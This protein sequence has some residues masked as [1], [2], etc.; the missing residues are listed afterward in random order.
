[1]ELALN[2][3]D[4]VARY[5]SGSGTETIVLQYTVKEGDITSN[6]DYR[7]STSL[8]SQNTEGGY[9][10]V[11]GHVRRKSLSPTTDSNLDISHI[12][13]MSD[14]HIIVIDGER[15]Q[16]LDVHFSESDEG[17]V[18]ARG[19]TLMIL[20]PFSAPV[21]VDESSPPILGLLLGANE[22]WASYS[23]GSGSSTLVF[24]YTIVVGDS[25]MPLEFHYRQFCHQTRDCISTKGLVVRLSAT[26]ELDAD[27]ITGFSEQGI[28]IA[29]SPE[30]GVTIDTSMAPVTTVVSTTTPT[31]A[32]TYG[33]GEIIDIILSFTDQVFLP[34]AMPTLLLNTGNFAS[35]YSGQDTDTL[36]FRFIS[37][38]SDLTSKFDWA[39][40]PATSSA[41]VCSVTCSIENANGIG[42]DIRFRDSENDSSLVEPLQNMI[43]FDPSTPQILSIR[44]DKTKSPY[45]HPSCTYTVGEEINIHVTFDRPVVVQGNA[46]SLVMNV[47][48]DVENNRAVHIPS[49]ST[50]YELAFLY[51]VGHGHSSNGASLQ[52]I[53]SETLCSLQLGE[54]TEI[55]GAASIPT[56]D[57]DLA[58]PPNSEHGLSG[59][60][61]NP[62]LIVTSGQ[63]SIFDVSS[64]PSDGDFSPGDTIEISVQFSRTVVVSG[65]PFLALDVGTSQSGIA[66][67]KDGS[68]TPILIFEY[69]VGLDHM[70][71]GLQYVDA[72]SLYLG[73]D[74]VNSG[75]IKQASTNPSIDA[76]LD[77]T[78]HGTV[79]AL[80]ANS[81][82][83]IDSREP[84][85][86]LIS[87]MPGEYSTGNKVLI[88]VQF[89]RP[90]VIDGKPSL[91]LK[92]G[93]KDRIAEY[94]S[95]PNYHTIQFSYTVQLGDSTESLDYWSDEELL[96]S[97]SM[98]LRLNGGWI[99][100]KSTNPVLDA[101]LHINPIDGFLDG[102]KVVG[103]TEGV[104]LFRD[105]KIGQRGKDFKIWFQSN[106]SSTGRALQVSELVKIDASIEYEVQGDLTIRDPGDLYG[107]AVS[108]HEGMLAVGAPGKQNPTPEIQVVTVHSE[109]AIEEHEV[110]VIA[111]SVNIERIHRIQ[112]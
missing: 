25:S 43:A 6:L 34:G 57:A 16:M 15:P 88:Q 90:V 14:T 95:Q 97:S 19:D 100:L 71:P 3:Y 67:F 39:L 99:R 79:G 18:F 77:L 53:C 5:I 110:Q 75:S 31:P 45:C 33:V 38:E 35:Y 49:M 8:I 56:L 69:V 10:P 29:T 101:D 70:T 102:D 36:T 78:F 109:S 103:V 112:R 94:D 89:S 52:Y 13:S 72:H 61:F 82:I 91:A 12:A 11:V 62:I 50:E 96:P 1:L 64:M 106:V 26:L 58:L 81:E 30:T 108:L 9:L 48:D 107:S 54:A 20:V 93:L 83:V 4:G 60:E 65:E 66:S 63:P 86:L 105:L 32:G 73:F 17:G 47:G 59:D 27:L 80:G 2:T 104:A 74:G 92:A 41:L 22:R 55:K 28:Q 84:F 98:S 23:S 111:N 85:I 51:I 44:T 37:K 21:V 87:A 46:V 68:G 40:D 76:N 24:S 7:D 42:V